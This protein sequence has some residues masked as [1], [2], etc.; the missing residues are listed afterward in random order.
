M[1]DTRTFTPCAPGWH[2]HARGPVTQEDNTV[3]TEDSYY[4][5]VGWLL[6]GEA[7]GEPVIVDNSYYPQP[8]SLTAWRRDVAGPDEQVLGIEAA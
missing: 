8:M 3:E 5:V 2:V 7:H 6:N 4:P 1:N